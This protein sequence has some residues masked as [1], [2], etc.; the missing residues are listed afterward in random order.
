MFISITITCI[1]GPSRITRTKRRSRPQRKTCKL[2][3]VSPTPQMFVQ[4]AGLHF[5]FECSEGTRDTFALPFP[6]NATKNSNHE[7]NLHFS[8]CRENYCIKV[9]ATP[10]QSDNTTA[11][12]QILSSQITDTLIIE[13]RLTYHAAFRICHSRVNDAKNVHLR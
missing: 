3:T 13:T 10:Y 7:M 5:S 11:I 2:A 1:L 9:L 12:T 6:L 4:C 8:K